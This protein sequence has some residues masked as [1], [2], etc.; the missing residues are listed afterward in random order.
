MSAEKKQ[1]NERTLEEQKESI[2]NQL[3]SEIISGI[4]NGNAPFFDKQNFATKERAYNPSNG[5]PYKNLNSLIL[6]MKQKEG[7]YEK[8]QWISLS[9]AK[10]LGANEDELKR[11]YESKDI[12]K[13]KVYYVKTSEIRPIY[14]L[15]DK[16]NKIP[17]L[18]EKGEQRV[19]KFGELL[20]K[21]KMVEQKD[22]NGNVKLKDN[23][24][25]FMKFATE[26]VEIKPT[27]ETDF[28]YNVAEFKTIN[29]DRLKSLDKKLEADYRHTFKHKEQS[30]QS[31]FIVIDDLHQKIYPNVLSAI[32]DYMYK[33]N[34]K[35]EYHPPFD[36]QEVKERQQNIEL[37]EQ[38][39][40]AYA[41]ANQQKTNQQEQKQKTSRG[42]SGAENTL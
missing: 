42:K 31:K 37:A 24:E 3:Q 14:E 29:R 13:A 5:I 25:P 11:V 2:L 22:N 40:Q 38:E 26:R 19:S 1:W 21:C 39:K 33:Q 10:F 30:M 16:G 36:R 32:K 7:N 12:P 15:D 8:N 28:L 18:D 27:Y 41:R 4:R 17:L 23:G 6:D 9:D 20:F 35:A 34:L